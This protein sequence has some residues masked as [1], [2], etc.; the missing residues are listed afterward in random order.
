MTLI[1]TDDIAGIDSLIA[2][3]MRSWFLKELNVDIPVLKIIG[4][5]SIADLSTEALGKV[6]WKGDWQVT[7]VET[8]SK[9]VIESA[10]AKDGTAVI[11]TAAQ[12]SK[13]SEK[14]ATARSTRGS[15]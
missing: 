1:L 8:D 7:S 11:L 4:G 15:Q 12:E 3:Y 13:E 10:E 2:V 5:H 14:T 6:P 9:P